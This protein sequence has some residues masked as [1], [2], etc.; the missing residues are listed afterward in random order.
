MTLD[1]ALR[2]VLVSAAI[3]MAAVVLRVAFLRAFGPPDDPVRRNSVPGLLSYVAFV[4]LAVLDGFGR[5][6]R[7]LSLVHT[8]LAVVAL[9]SGLYGAGQMVRLRRRGVR[10]PDA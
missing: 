4:L 10:P 7:P 1:D 9:G 6:G 8:V 3:L 2:V 5:F